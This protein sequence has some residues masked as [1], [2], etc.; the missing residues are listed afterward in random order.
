MN[1]RVFQIW[2]IGLTF[3][4]S[5]CKYR[6]TGLLWGD[7]ACHWWIP[8]AK[9]SDVELSCFLWAAPKQMVQQTIEMPVIWEAIPLIITSL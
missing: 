6:N 3:R 2:Y 5:Q 4:K 9:A 7:S 8:L 1:E